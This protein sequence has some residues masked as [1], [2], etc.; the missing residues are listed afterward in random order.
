MC[1]FSRPTTLS[2][3]EYS[4]SREQNRL[5]PHSPRFRTRAIV[6]SRGTNNSVYHFTRDHVILFALS[7]SRRRGDL[8][9]TVLRGAFAGMSFAQKALNEGKTHTMPCDPRTWEKRAVR[10]RTGNPRVYLRNQIT[11]K[12]HRARVWFCCC[13]CQEERDLSSNDYLLG[14]FELRMNGLFA[15]CAILIWHCRRVLFAV[16]Q[17]SILFVL[18]L[19]SSAIRLSPQR[20]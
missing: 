19:S 2:A 13:C 16:A 18:L 12:A 9:Q 15:A 1:V 8:S 5:C 14:R 3:S 10:A 17:G 20:P 11:K 4:I 7:S 6:T